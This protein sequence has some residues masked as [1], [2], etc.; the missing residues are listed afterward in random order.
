MEMTLAPGWQ[1][2]WEATDGVCQ[3][4]SENK[5]DM[6]RSAI[7]IFTAKY[8]GPLDTFACYEQHLRTPRILDSKHGVP[9][10]RKSKF[11]HLKMRRIGEYDWMDGLLFESEIPGFYTQYLGTFTSR[12]GILV[13]FAVRREQ[14]E[15]RTEEIEGM[16]ERINIY[17]GGGT[18]RY[19]IGES[20]NRCNGNPISDGY[21]AA[22]SKGLRP[23]H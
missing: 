21:A 6:D 14:L 12:I 4:Y 20:S 10:G 16:I 1:C 15:S 2:H 7:A 3:K 23:A 17:E 19:T 9:E 22:A 8:R 18:A 13:T 5:R 11:K